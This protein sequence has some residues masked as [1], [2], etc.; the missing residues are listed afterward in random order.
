MIQSREERT[1]ELLDVMAGFTHTEDCPCLICV[2]RRNRQSLKSSPSL[3]GEIICPHDGLPC[4]DDDCPYTY[5]CDH[6]PGDDLSG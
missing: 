2:D 3:E 1:K 6:V 4:T 5:D